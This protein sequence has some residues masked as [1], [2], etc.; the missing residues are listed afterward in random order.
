MTLASYPLGS[1]TTTVVF[2]PDAGAKATCQAAPAATGLVSK[3][4]SVMLLDV[5]GIGQATCDRK[6]VTDFGKQLNAATAA[7]KKAGAKRVVLLGVGTGATMVSAAPGLSAD[8][9][10]AVAAAPSAGDL[11]LA[12]NAS[13]ANKPY[14]GAASAK[15]KASLVA[16]KQFVG[17]MPAKNKWLV[18]T[19]SA[20]GYG[21]LKAKKTGFPALVADWI[22]GRYR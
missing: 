13:K 15:D 8:A 21:L 3:G 22:A 9:I 10:V 7:A 2:V 12:A 4:V 6:V 18:Q 20:P 19:S 14:L 16:M 1:G 17:A 5:C 11:A